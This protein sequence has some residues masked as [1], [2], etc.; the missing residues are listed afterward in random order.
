MTP[1]G[2]FPFGEPVQ[3]VVQTD[4]THKRVFVLGVYASAVHARWI[5]PD[6]KTVVKTHNLTGLQELPLM[7]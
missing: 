3:E 4:C 2:K 7:N 5:G 1:I 6:S